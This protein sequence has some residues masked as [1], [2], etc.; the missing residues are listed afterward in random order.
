MFQHV[1]CRKLEYVEGWLCRKLNVGAQFPTRQVAD[2]EGGAAL[3]SPRHLQVSIEDKERGEAVGDD[4]HAC[5]VGDLV[6]HGE[7]VA[8][9]LLLTLLLSHEEPVAEAVIEGQDVSLHLCYVAKQDG[10]GQ[11]GLVPSLSKIFCLC[12]CFCS[13]LLVQQ[14]WCFWAKSGPGSAQLNWSVS[15]WIC[16]ED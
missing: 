1:A 13:C 14:G 7:V 12:L 8:I 3:S 2:E 6:V 16:L 4:R 10:D 15:G 11:L 9:V 5:R